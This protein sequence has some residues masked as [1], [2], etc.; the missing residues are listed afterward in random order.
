M[1]ARARGATRVEWPTAAPSFMH[2][3]T[4]PRADSV[5]VGHASADGSASGWQR[6]VILSNVRAN[7]LIMTYA[8][9]GYAPF[10]QNW[11]TGLSALGLDEFVVVALDA[12]IWRLL[13]T[14]RL[15]AHAIHF[16]LGGG[17]EGGT[18]AHSWYDPAY[19]RLMGTQ[20]R[21]VLTVFG[22][23]SFDLL[24][25]DADVIWRQSP[26]P[27]LEAASRRHCELQAIL[28][29]APG[30]VRSVSWDA[31]VRVRQPHPKA[32]CAEHCLNA[33]FLYLRRH[34]S[35]RTLLER[36]DRM[37]R[38]QRERDTNQKWLNWVLATGGVP[39]DSAAARAHGL[40]YRR[41]GSH[42]LRWARRDGAPISCAL[43][44][45]AFPNGAALSA[46]GP[47]PCGCH[48]DG[49][50]ASRVRAAVSRIVAAHLNYALSADGKVC[51]ARGAGLWLT[52]SVPADRASV[53]ATAGALARARARLVDD[54][55]VSTPR[56][57]EGRVVLPPQYRLRRG[58][59]SRGSP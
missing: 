44:P 8:D 20:P 57:G 2:G 55:N 36:W 41:N 50:C 1:R 39:V 28:G 15:E 46:L 37:L 54:V 43:D 14:L 13:K 25:T 10:L 51:T 24:V 33:G 47:V 48:A 34:A 11:L 22:S 56:E 49:A 59:G 31:A 21:R 58:G 9:G 52:S 32:N 23:G 6:D 18:T 4:L 38:R 5:S 17:R 19:R 26:W 7:R 40:A 27:V 53:T 35:V 42:P 3:A 45:S 29:G 12:T 16:G 30:A